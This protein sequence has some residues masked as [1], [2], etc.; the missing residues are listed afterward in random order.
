M[1]D[2][3][4]K[5]REGSGRRHWRKPIFKVT[6]PAKILLFLTEFRNLGE[7][8]TAEFPHIKRQYSIKK[9]YIVSGR[10]PQI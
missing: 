5:I 1:S 8:V 9:H 2:K 6:V 3:V 4:L 10:I 7:R